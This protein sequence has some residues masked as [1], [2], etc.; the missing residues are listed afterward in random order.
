VDKTAVRVADKL[1]FQVGFAKDLCGISG[2][3]TITSSYHDCDLVVIGCMPRRKKTHF[4]NK[5]HHDCIKSFLLE[6]SG[7]T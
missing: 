1:E 6:F 3:K 2:V 5:Q 4:G 7:L